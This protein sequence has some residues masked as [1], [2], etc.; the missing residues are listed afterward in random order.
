M[1]ALL[2]LVLVVVAV[3]A[4]GFL[5]LGYWAGRTGTAAHPS[6]TPAGTSG[7]INTERARERAAELGEKA[8]GAAAKVQEGMS[9]AGVTAKIKAK[10]ALDDSVRSRSIN[11]TT[12]GTVV[13]LSGTVESV[14]E[15]DRAIALARETDGVSQVVDRLRVQ[16]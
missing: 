3:V 16:R 6:P 9:E 8:A 7:T 10:M 1:R 11:V 2:R 5:F 13:T 14:K 4:V 12:D 15:H